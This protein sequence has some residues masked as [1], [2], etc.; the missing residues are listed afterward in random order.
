MALSR[1]V[2]SSIAGRAAGDNDSARNRAEHGA[3]AVLSNRPHS[4]L[5]QIKLR[6][7]AD[8][9]IAWTHRLIRSRTAVCWP[10]FRKRP[11]TCLRLQPSHGAIMHGWDDLDWR[12]F[13][14]YRYEARLGQKTECSS[15][16]I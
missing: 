2:S 1:R 16:K 5:E 12:C 7:A 10:S 4:A 9:A 14:L 8:L 6:V 13:A 3:R 11:E 15:M